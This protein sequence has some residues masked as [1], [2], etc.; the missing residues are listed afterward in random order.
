MKISLINKL[1]CHNIKN[2]DFLEGDSHPMKKK[3]FIILFILL[4]LSA[5]FIW[6]Y[7]FQYIEEGYVIRA[8]TDTL[9][10]VNEKPPNFKGKS[11]EEISKMYRFKGT[12]YTIPLT[13]KLLKNEYNI[14]QKVRIHYDGRVYLSAP[15]R[16][17]N[18]SLITKVKE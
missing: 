17:E 13:N 8:G 12:V 2:K 14:G 11:S 15:G 7:K 3:I 5:P 4:L 6:A 1:Y 10:V 9:W 16:A 18:T